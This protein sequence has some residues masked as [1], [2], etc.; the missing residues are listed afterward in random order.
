MII[1]IGCDIVQH[2]ITSKLS[3]DKK[4]RALLRIFSP[5]ERKQLNVIHK[6]RFISGR[7]AAKEA[8]LKSLGLIMEDGISL[9]DVQILKSKKGKPWVELKGEVKKI[10]KKLGVNSIQLSISHSED[11]S[12]AIAIAERF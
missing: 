11:N 8:V 4:P 9:R 2:E 5:V 3:W 6:I 1:G 12:I 10:A 7:F